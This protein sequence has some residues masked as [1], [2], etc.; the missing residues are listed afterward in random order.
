MPLEDRAAGFSSN[1]TT[2]QNPDRSDGLP[3]DADEAEVLRWVHAA[4]SEGEGII[5]ADPSYPKMDKLIA[6]VLGDQY[7]GKRPKY[8][9]DIVINRIKKSI[10]QHVSAMTDV[11]PLFGFKTENQDFKHQGDILNTLVILWW[12]NTFADLEVGSVLQYS[13]TVGSGYLVVEYDKNFGRFGDIRLFPKDPRDVIPIR[14]SRDRSVQSWQGV[15]IREVHTLNALRATYPDK[16]HLLTVKAH[17]YPKH[18]T[19]KTVWRKISSLITPTTTLDGLGDRKPKTGEMPGAVNFYKTYFWDRSINTTSDSIVMGNPNTNW[20]YIVPPGKPLY[21]RGRLVTATDHVILYDGP[22]PNW[23]GMFP[24]VKF[25]LDPW[26]WL[27]LGLG[28]AHDLMPVQEALNRTVN[29]IFTVLGQ[30]ANRGTMFNNK[31]VSESVVK[32]FDSRKP[33]WK[34]R[35][36]PVFGDGV[37]VID[38]PELPPWT[39]NFLQ[40]AF[41]EFDN[42]AGTANLQAL[43]NLRQSPSGETIQKYMEALTPEI[44]MESRLL[45]ASL[46]EVGEL[47]KCNM[48][49]FY[50]TERRILALGDAGLDLEDFDYD[51]GTLVPAM[52]QSEPGYMP[53]LDRGLSRDERAQYFM[54]L[55]TLYIAPNSLL[56]LHATER[57]MMYVQLSRMGYMDF[58]TLMEMLEI[59]NVGSPPPIPLPV[60]GAGAED[61][62]PSIDPATGLP[63]M[64]P[65]T[66]LRQPAT[67]TERLIAQ[68]MLGIGMTENPTGRKASGQKPPEMKTKTDES[69]GQRVTMSESG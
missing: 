20:S 30:A 55:F 43:L 33:G 18:G 41:Q 10:K 16:A 56:S 13:L 14:P 21:P 11:R 27:L 8:L 63:S 68:Q 44:R 58:W 35:T 9:T 54:K 38:P 50:S 34:L 67:I 15:V 17:A 39:M 45:E 2:P 48:F 40:M 26:P 60:E 6:Y 62:V 59:P 23:H 61:M 4:I 28:L 47:V 31:A 22:N 29:D 42:L 69:G 57:K 12:V 5:R 46:R 51:P 25:A 53:E 1:L 65:P 66:E 7:T 36:N 32:S 24:V 49:Q 3:N 64:V 19:V 52:D 37:K